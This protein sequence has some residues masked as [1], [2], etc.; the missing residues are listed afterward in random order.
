MGRRRPVGGPGR[1]PPSVREENALLYSSRHRPCSL[2]R[3]LLRST[4]HPAAASSSRAAASARSR[5]SWL[6]AR[7]RF[8]PDT[9]LCARDPS[10][11]RAI[12]S[13]FTVTHGPTTTKKKTLGC[14]TITTSCWIITDQEL[15]LQRGHVVGAG[16][17]VDHGRRRRR[18]RGADGQL[19]PPPPLPVATPAGTGYPR[20]ALDAGMTK[21]SAARRGRGAAR[22]RPRRGH[23]HGGR[24]GSGHVCFGEVVRCGAQSKE[25]T[26]RMAAG[27]GFGWAWVLAGITASARD[28]PWRS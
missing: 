9:A 14:E 23:G 24:T 28:F 17:R 4:G 10:R 12:R 6:A 18:G 20:R 16:V 25:G 22:R 21:Q 5:S 3:S 15:D 27:L 2:S 19:P 13:Q 1:L 8:S 7:P 26:K 11:A